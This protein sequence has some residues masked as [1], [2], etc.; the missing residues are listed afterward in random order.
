[1]FCLRRNVVYLNIF[2]IYTLG[3]TIMLNLSVSQSIKSITAI[4]KNV[5]KLTITSEYYPES[6]LTFRLCERWSDGRWRER[7]Y[8]WIICNDRGNV[9]TEFTFGYN[10]KEKINSF[11]RTL[12]EYNKYHKRYNKAKVLDE[13]K[14]RR[15]LRRIS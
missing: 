2:F 1:M 12:S 6:N 10:R 5:V 8:Y 9:V 4:S 11:A 13:R 7:I 15:V 14:I 3:V